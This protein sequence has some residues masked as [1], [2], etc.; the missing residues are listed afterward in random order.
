MPQGTPRE[1]SVGEEINDTLTF[2]GDGRLFELTAPSDGTLVVRLSWDPARGR[3]ELALADTRFAHFPDNWSEEIDRF[4]LQLGEHLGEPYTGY[5]RVGEELNPL[6]VGSRLDSQT[7]A[8]TWSPGVGFVGTYD[9]VFVRSLGERPLARRE[10]RFILQPK[11]SGHI[12]TQVAIDAPQSQ[13]DLTLPFILSGWA[14]DLDPAVG[15]GIETLHVWA[16][17]LSGGLRCSSEQRRMA[18]C[19]WMSRPSTANSSALQGSAW[20]SKGSSPATTISRCLRGAASPAASR[21]P[22]LSA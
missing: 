20:W 9:L 7:G 15:T 18:A 12:G 4:E 3:L 19:G 21:R 1:I 2:H 5:V 11:G 13:Q 8:F 16:Y 22:D 14:A 17:S 6:P 10:V